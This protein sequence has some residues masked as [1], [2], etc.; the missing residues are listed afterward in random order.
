MNSRLVIT[1]P[2]D[3]TNFAE[4]DGVVYSINGITGLRYYRALAVSDTDAVTA[5]IQ[6]GCVEIDTETFNGCKKLTEITVPVSVKELSNGCLGYSDWECPRLKQIYYGGTIAQ[7]DA[8]SKP[9]YLLKP[10]V[11]CTD[12]TIAADTW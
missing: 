3:C 12:G 9:Q 5:V 2:E 10:Q 6:E 11:I 1:V 4:K 8:I 7:W